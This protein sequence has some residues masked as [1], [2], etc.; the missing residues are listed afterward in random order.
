MPPPPIEERVRER[1]G[2]AGAVRVGELPR[3]PELGH[4]ARLAGGDEDRVVAEPLAPARRVRD[5]ALERPP[6]AELGAVRAERDELADVARAPRVALHPRERLEQPPDL[7][8]G[9]EPRGADSRPAVEAVDLDPGV[10]AEHPRPLVDE[11]PPVR[12]L[13]A[14]VVGVRVPDL[15]RVRVGGEQLDL[16]AGKRGPQLVELVR[17]PRGEARGYSAHSAP[18]ISSCPSRSATSSAGVSEPAS[19]TSI[20][21]RRRP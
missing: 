16:P 6:A 13:P 20:A 7:V 2:G 12:R 15:G 21:T 18:R 10:L 4:R 19:A 17:V 8:A 1:G 3:V 11:R 14:R 5:P 9:R